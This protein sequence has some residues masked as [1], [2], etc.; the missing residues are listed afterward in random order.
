MLRPEWKTVDDRTAYV[1]L[2]DGIVYGNLER[3]INTPDLDR[4]AQIHIYLPGEGQMKEFGNRVRFA[5]LL[6]QVLRVITKQP[7]YVVSQVAEG[8]WINYF[9]PHIEI[10]RVDWKH[11][12][13][14]VP[15]EL[16]LSIKMGPVLKSDINLR[17][18]TAKLRALGLETGGTGD[19]YDR[20]DGYGERFVRLAASAALGFWEKKRLRSVK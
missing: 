14:A 11:D 9:N 5:G 17:R 1:A 3:L 4:L 20:F 7:G 10:A 8:H 16:E 13:Y 18:V 12:V 19:Y 15:N 6:A 2:K